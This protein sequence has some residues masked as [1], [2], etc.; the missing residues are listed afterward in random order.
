MP[1][2]R[3]Y[4]YKIQ[5]LDPRKG[6][7]IPWAPSRATGITSPKSLKWRGSAWAKGYNIERRL[8]DSTTWTRVASNV[9]DN[10]A[11]PAPIYNDV[12]ATKGK[13]YIY[14]IQACGVGGAVSD[15]LSLGPMRA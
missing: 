10:V 3:Y 12:S 6:F 4:A 2:V 1:L 11:G 15:W 8:T 7:P 5:G 14:R 9:P 13:D